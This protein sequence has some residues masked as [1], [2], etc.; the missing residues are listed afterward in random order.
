MSTR[1]STKRLSALRRRVLRRRTRIKQ[2]RAA[3]AA[4]SARENILCSTLICEEED[5]GELLVD[6][7]QARGSRWVVSRTLGPPNH[8]LWALND[9]Q[10]PISSI[11]TEGTHRAS[12]THQ[13]T[14][15]N[16]GPTNP[17]TSPLLILIPTL[18]AKRSRSHQDENRRAQFRR[19]SPCACNLLVQ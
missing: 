12:T 18:T 14:A 1:L 13:I 17:T 8:L 10:P 6:G 5:R 2:S 9:R 19:V 11:R 4:A 7:K 3:A 15:N 16:I